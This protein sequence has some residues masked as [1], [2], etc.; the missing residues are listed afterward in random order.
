[1]KSIR[2]QKEIKQK[3]MNQLEIKYKCDKSKRNQINQKEI[4]QKSHRNIIEI[5]S[6]SNRNQK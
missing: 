6:K 1:M 2:N 4:K 5:N 3:C